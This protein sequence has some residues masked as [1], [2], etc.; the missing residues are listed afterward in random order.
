MMI[1]IAAV[2]LLSLQLTASPALAARYLL[3]YDSVDGDE[4]RYEDDTK[5]NTAMNH[6]VDTWDYE[7]CINIAYDVWNTVTDV[8]FKDDTN[9]SVSW[10]GLYTNT[11]GTDEIY[12]N[13]YYLD[14]DTTN[15]QKNTALHEL[16]H[17][18]GLD[19]S[20]SNNLMYSSQTSR[21]TLGTQDRSDYDYLWC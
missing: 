17:A 2:A 11:A 12:F 20:I 8:T 6:A 14:S 5:Y 18:L 3:G 4:I 15:Q 10:T 9:S 21:T 1:G 19:H 7:G 16:G 13:T